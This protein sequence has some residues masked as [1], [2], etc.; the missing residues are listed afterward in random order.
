MTGEDRSACA[1][2]ALITSLFTADKAALLAQKGQHEIGRTGWRKLMPL[3]TKP[4]TNCRPHV[5]L[6]TEASILLMKPVLP[7][8]PIVV[9]SRVGACVGI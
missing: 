7:A 3:I 8:S 9:R 4:K 1:T 5:S 2:V 6:P